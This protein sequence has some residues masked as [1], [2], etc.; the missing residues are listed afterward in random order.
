VAQKVSRVAKA[1]PFSARHFFFLASCL[2]LPCCDSI[3]SKRYDGK[4]L[5]KSSNIT[6]E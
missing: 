5:E 1:F 6:I 3:W 2:V 4:R